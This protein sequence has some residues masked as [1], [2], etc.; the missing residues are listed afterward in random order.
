[1]RTRTI[2]SAL[3]KATRLGIFAILLSS[4]GF[5]GCE[6]F[7]VVGVSNPG[8][9]GGIVGVGTTC[10]VPNQTGNVTLQL[11]SAVTPTAP[12]WPSDVQ[13]IFVSLRG[14]EALPADSS[15]DDSP[16]WQELAPDLATQPA[17][18]DLMAR[19]ASSCGPGVFPEASVSTGVYNRL[20]LRLVPNQPDA[21]E[22]VPAENACGKAG[23]NCVVASGG[24]IRLLTSDDPTELRIP[25][26]GITGGFFRIVPDD[27]IRLAIE[28]DPRSSLVLR[29]GDAAQLLPTFSVTRQSSCESDSE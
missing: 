23:F 26:N 13:H 22:P 19:A 6:N 27:H 16:A 3:A 25:A 5:A 10:P 21:S 17:Q 15:G 24:G 18:V 11:N 9:G 1:M 2:P 14:I 28:F 29:S 4:I 20:R 7:C 8:G 12:S